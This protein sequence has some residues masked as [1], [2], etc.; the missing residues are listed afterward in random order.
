MDRWMDSIILDIVMI[1]SVDTRKEV[2]D[3]PKND[4]RVS[5]IIRLTEQQRRSFK[6]CAARRGK[7]MQDL[8]LELMMEQ[9][10][11]D[12]EQARVSYYG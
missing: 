12:E 6:V 11:Q 5:V 9:V 3:M 10:T 1:L 7:T 2:Q 8:A 4:D